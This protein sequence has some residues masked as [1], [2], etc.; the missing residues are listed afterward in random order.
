MRIVFAF[1]SVLL[2]VIAGLVTAPF[3]IDLN[4]HKEMIAQQVEKA[5]GYVLTINGDIDVSAVPMPKLS[6]AGVTVRKATQDKAFLSLDSAD[7]Q[8]ALLPLLSRQIQVNA[9]T[10]ENP[11]ATLIMDEAGDNF[12]PVLPN[13]ADETATTDAASGDT[14]QASKAPNVSID[15]LRIQGGAIAYNGLPITLPDF[16]VRLDSLQGPFDVAGT[17][18][19]QGLMYHV[20]GTVGALKPGQDMPIQMDVT[21]ND[22]LANVE[23]SGSVSQIDQGAEAMTLAGEVA[24]KIGQLNALL[25]GLGQAALPDMIG[26]QSLSARMTI[27]GGLDALNLEQGSLG[28]KGE[29]IDFIGTISGVNNPSAMKASVSLPTLPGQG[30]MA[31]SYQPNALG[32]TFNDFAIRP[33][34][35]DWLDVLPDAAHDAALPAKLSGDVNINS[36]TDSPMRVDLDGVRLDGMPVDG[37]VSY[38]KADTTD[39]RDTVTLKLTT[40]TLSL[41]DPNDDKSGTNVDSAVGNGDT[42]KALSLPRLPV[43]PVDIVFDVTAKGVRLPAMNVKGID[44]KGAWRGTYLVVDSASLD[45]VNG[46]SLSLSGMI[47][48][49]DAMQGIDLD[50]ATKTQSLSSV[51]Q[52]FGQQPVLFMGQPVE[53]IAADI[54]YTGSQDEGD[55]QTTVKALGFSV[56]AKGRMNDPL[57][58]GIPEQASISVTHPNASSALKTLIPGLNPT[59][60]GALSLQAAL[61]M[62]GKRVSLSG[63]KLKAGDLDLSGSAAIDASGTRPSI[64]ADVKAGLLPVSAIMGQKTSTSA[65]GGSGGGSAASLSN[66][67]WSRDA[68]NTQALRAFDLDVDMHAD[69]L[70][71][72]QWI[73][74]DVSA[75][76]TLKAGRFALSPLKASVFGGAMEMTLNLDAPEA[77]KPVVLS[78]TITFTDVQMGPLVRAIT[79]QRKDSL[80]GV[81]SLQFN[82]KGS[83]ISSSA[84]AFSLT[85]NGR[86][87]VTSPIV[88]GVDLEGLDDALKNM[89]SSNLITSLLGAANKSLGGG[90]TAFK[91]IDHSFTMAQGTVVLDNFVLETLNSTGTITND[92]TISLSQWAL[93][94]TSTVELVREAGTPLAVMTLKGPLNAPTR[95]VKSDA[96]RTLV[97]NK[98]GDKIGDA[99]DGVIGEKGSNLIRGLLGGGSSQTGQVANDNQA[100]TSDAESQPAANPIA[101]IEQEAEKLIRGLFDKF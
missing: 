1:L 28:Y 44:A 98:W 31:I 61:A 59:L 95:S 80:T 85:G 82:V 46:A 91:D 86:L 84:L 58:G 48:D 66:G 99:L 33:V 2:L 83:G 25:Q 49:T 65:A 36:G 39:A 30:G 89:N 18:G 90:E 81:G 53:A 37:S 47:K 43:L 15:M 73:L 51:L 23:F 79:K 92:G 64:K 50:M 22:N 94:L 75:D 55:F 41:S 5:T 19:L 57:S 70:I 3:F 56:G 76:T 71:Y 12:M 16:K 6:V 21:V 38:T 101:P 4:Q 60:S 13:N 87:N 11:Q 29:A 78:E 34:L 42:P 14:S 20:D 27:A 77:R 72:N 68:M 69:K 17:L 54:N 62:D 93:D 52:A 97:N 88:H 100:D 9:I 32:L 10:L 8:V 35:V 40:G 74:S 26:G 45:D 96:L 67:P 24:L 63:I 7:V